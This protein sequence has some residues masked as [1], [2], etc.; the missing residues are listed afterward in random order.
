ML[1]IAL[2]FVAAPFPAALFQS[3]VV[4]LWPKQEM[5]VFENP[6]SM[7]VAIC[8]Y[9][10]FFGLLIGVPAWL[11]I[12]K[13]NALNVRTYA[14]AGLL[15]G[16]LPVGAALGWTIIQAHTSTYVLAYNLAF[17]GLGGVAARWTF[18]SI[19][20]RAGRALAPENASV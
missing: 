14:M 10:Y 4:A 16:L 12:R 20:R 15:V 5:G 18:W 11:V 19:S 9:Y 7:F 1:R 13:R 17:F 3:I 6:P 8:I 2:A